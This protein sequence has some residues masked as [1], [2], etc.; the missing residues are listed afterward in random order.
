MSSAQDIINNIEDASYI[1]L[2]EVSVSY[3]LDSPI[4]KRR[5]LESVNVR[6]S[7]RDLITWSKYTGWDP[8]TNMM[9]NRISG[10]DYFNQPQTWGATFSIFLNW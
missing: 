4:V 10:E 5:G 6:L 7:F 8:E 1:K 3:L 9:Q 2:R